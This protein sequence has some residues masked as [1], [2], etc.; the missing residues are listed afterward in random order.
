MRFANVVFFFFLLL[1]AFTIFQK[2]RHFVTNQKIAHLGSIKAQLGSARAL[3]GA[4]TGTYMRGLC[5]RLP[6]SS[7]GLAALG[8]VSSWGSRR[9]SC[10]RA[11]RRCRP[12]CCWPQHPRQDAASRSSR[13]DEHVV[14]VPTASVLPFL[15]R[16][17]LHVSFLIMFDANN[18]PRACIPPIHS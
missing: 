18:P 5:W 16:P 15:F 4:C 9:G 1:L 17:L 13:Y 3:K 12:V 11:P 6:R 14:R 10:P 7:W 8:P 2:N